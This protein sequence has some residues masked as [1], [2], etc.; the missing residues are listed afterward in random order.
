VPMRDKMNDSTFLA[1]FTLVGASFSKFSLTAFAEY[2]T[3]VCRDLQTAPVCVVE[4]ACC[5]GH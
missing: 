3:F 5:I 1:S 4:L 2:R